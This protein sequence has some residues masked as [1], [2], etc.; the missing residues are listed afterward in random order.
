MP[1]YRYY[2]ETCL[3]ESILF[4]RINDIVTECPI[5]ENETIIKM[6]SIPTII[7]IEDKEPSNRKPGSLTREYIE[8]N[9][10]ILKQQKDEATQEEYE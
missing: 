5:C 10:E 3:N 2:C 8:A 7:H 9:K 4:H 1:R 6:V